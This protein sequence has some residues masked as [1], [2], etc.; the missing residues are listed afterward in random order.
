MI[1]MTFAWYKSGRISAYQ[2]FL[3]SRGNRCDNIGHL[4]YQ[5]LR[6]KRSKSGIFEPIPRAIQ[7]DVYVCVLGGLVANVEKK[8]NK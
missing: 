2:S 1:A 7:T 4:L 6:A 3:A 5:D 8:I